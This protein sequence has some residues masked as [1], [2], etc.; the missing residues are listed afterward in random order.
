[1]ATTTPDGIVTLRLRAHAIDA[2][3]IHPSSVPASSERID[4][5]VIHPSSVPASS[6]RQGVDA[7]RHHNPATD[8]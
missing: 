5:Y 3:V 1:M 7:G 2:Y 8:K 4:A 6:E